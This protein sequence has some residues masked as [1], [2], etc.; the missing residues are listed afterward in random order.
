MAIGKDVYCDSRLIISTLESLYPESRLALSTPADAGIRKLLQSWTDTAV[1]FNATKMMP[2]WTSNGLLQNKGFLDDREKL[3][4]KR[5]TAE[6]MEANRPDGLQHLRQAFDLLE[7]MFLA[8]GRTWVL[9]TD[10]IT[11]ADIDAVWAFAWLLEDPFMKGSLPEEFVND[12]RLPKALSYIRRFMDE[13]KRK[14]LQAPKPTTLKGDAM[15]DR[16]LRAALEHQPTEFISDDPLSL[17]VG[18]EVQVFASDYGSSHKD[19]GSIVG[20]TLAEVVI[21]NAKGLHIHFPRWNFRINKLKPPYSSSSALQASSPATKDLKM[22]LIYHP[23]S[24]YTRK[25][26]MLALE[27]GLASQMTLQKVVVCPI[28]FP[29]WS[30][31]NEDVAVYNPMAKIP[32]LVTDEVPDGIFDSRTICDYLSATSGV[33]AKKDKKFW[34]MRTLH[35]CA[36]GIMDAIILIVYEVRIREPK[37]I[38]LPEWIEGQK[39]KMKRGLDRFEIAAKD[40]VLHSPRP[41]VPASADEVAVVVATVA[42]EYMPYL[43]VSWREGRPKLQKFIEAWVERDSFVSSLPDKDWRGS[44]EADSRAARL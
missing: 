37:G 20:L 28:P 11:L 40:R 2:Y 33:N 3:M 35:A 43:N 31:N 18:D 4:G 32:C 41:G 24:P 8:D 9:G 36:D 26:Y 13:V 7:T 29:G 44:L 14:K 12:K 1:F 5:M 10:E 23:F 17:N 27:L 42:T 38:Q 25:V 34:Q 39:T 16:V 21:R 19:R 6:G 30:D 22:R 15:R